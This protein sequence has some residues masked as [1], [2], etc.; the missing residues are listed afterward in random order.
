M[1][2]KMMILSQHKKAQ[3]KDETP[4][5]PISSKV[6]SAAKKVATVMKRVR[7]ISPRNQILK[8]NRM[9]PRTMISIVRKNEQRLPVI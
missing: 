9:L 6:A 3:T 2:M 7:Q 8:R 1:Q 5:T 4:S